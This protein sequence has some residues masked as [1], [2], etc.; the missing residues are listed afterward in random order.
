MEKHFHNFQGFAV[1]SYRLNFES[2]AA[3]AAQIKVHFSD[4]SAEQLVERAQEK[5]HGPRDVGKLR[6]YYQRSPPFLGAHIF[7]YLFCIS[8]Y[9]LLLPG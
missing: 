3:S 9:L 7:L 2:I 6:A 8:L 4:L 1:G 5:L